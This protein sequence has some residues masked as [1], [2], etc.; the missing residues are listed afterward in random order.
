[1]ESLYERIGFP[2]V[3]DGTTRHFETEAAMAVRHAV[4]EE[5]GGAGATPG[6]MAY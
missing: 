3:M 4:N 6:A 5:L 1:M 2:P